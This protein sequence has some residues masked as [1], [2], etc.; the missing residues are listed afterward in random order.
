MTNWI[1]R[2]ALL[3]VVGSVMC[4]ALVVGCGGGGDDDDAATTNNTAAP[5]AKDAGEE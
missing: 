4:S 2:F 3:A 5:A 1:N